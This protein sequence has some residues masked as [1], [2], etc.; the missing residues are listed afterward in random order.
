M[1]DAAKPIAPLDVPGR[2]HLFTA[3]DFGEL[4]PTGKGV[5]GELMRRIA[6][7]E[8]RWRLRAALAVLSRRS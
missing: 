4:V 7:I 2:V 1:T 5:G 8:L 3:S 6:G